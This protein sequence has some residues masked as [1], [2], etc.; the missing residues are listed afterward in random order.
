MIHGVF[1]KSRFI[2]LIL[3]YITFVTD[4]EETYKI[5]SAYHQFFAVQKAV[6]STTHAVTDKT[7]K[8]G[9]VWHT[10]GS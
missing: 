3:N 1:E 6:E 5:M 10:Q 7:K 9:V 4:G 8:V 2:D